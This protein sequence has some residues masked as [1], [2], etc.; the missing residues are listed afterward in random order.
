MTQRNIP[1][2]EHDA[3]TSNK[4]IQIQNASHEDTA[5][6]EAILDQVY[7]DGFA[8]GQDSREDIIPSD[9]YSDGFNYLFIEVLEK[10]VTEYDDMAQMTA[11]N[12]ARALLDT[13]NNQ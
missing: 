9:V 5:E 11:I 8:D 10:F 7:N 12:Q 1:A 3:Y 6:L 13:I 2:Y 4:V